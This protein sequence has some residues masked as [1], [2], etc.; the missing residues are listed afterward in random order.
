MRL[1]HMRNLCVTC[2]TGN[3]FFQGKMLLRILGKGIK[4][5][6]QFVSILCDVRYCVKEH[7]PLWQTFADSLLTSWHL[8][9]ST[10]NSQFDVQTL[11]LP[12]LTQ[13]FARVK[14]SILVQRNATT[15]V[16]A[17]APASVARSPSISGSD[18]ID[19]GPSNTGGNG[20]VPE[21]TVHYHPIYVDVL[22]TLTEQ[23]VSITRSGAAVS[24]M[25]TVWQWL[26]TLTSIRA[27]PQQQ[28]LQRKRD[29]E[30]GAVGAAPSL[31]PLLSPSGNISTAASLTANGDAMQVQHQ[32]HADSALLQSI[33][34]M[35]IMAQQQQ[36]V[37]ANGS[38]ALGVAS[39]TDA[40]AVRHLS[41]IFI[42]SR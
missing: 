36:H 14:A 27:N 13:Y 1:V 12:L 10:L 24:F 34:R 15:N 22:I 37:Y 18:F 25:H 7:T 16:N 21:V 26:G 35:T 32:K 19:F 30:L 33:S 31:V 17:S 2:R 38:C 20:G 3:L 42:L 40:A 6:R 5:R 4:R 8:I 39:Q 9:C 29:L 28:V 11:L 41:K 23:L